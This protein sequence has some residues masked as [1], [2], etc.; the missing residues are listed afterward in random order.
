MQIT[1]MQACARVVPM[2]FYYSKGMILRVGF[3][4]VT[5]SDNAL[6]LYTGGTRFKST[7]TNDY[8]D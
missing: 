3:S 4:R 8:H 2:L 1:K 7:S 5:S 6:E